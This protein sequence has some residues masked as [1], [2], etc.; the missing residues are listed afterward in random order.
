LGDFKGLLEKS[1]DI[2][3]GEN[4]ASQPTQRTS[5]PRNSSP[6]FSQSQMILNQTQIQ[7]S[8]QFQNQ[9]PMQFQAQPRAMPSLYNPMN[10]QTPIQNVNTQ[11]RSSG[12]FQPLQ[13][14]SSTTS[15]VAQPPAWSQYSGFDNS[16][17]PSNQAINQGRVDTSS[18]NRPG[19]DQVD[20]LGLGNL[21][22]KSEGLNNKSK[23]SK[24][25]EADDKDRDTEKEKETDDSP[26][27]KKTEAAPGFI[28]RI[29]GSFFKKPAQVHLPDES[30][31]P[32]KW[33]PQNKRWF[34]PNAKPEE[35]AKVLP[36]PPTAPKVSSFAQQTNVPT[37]ASFN[38]TPNNA[39]QNQPSAAAAPNFGYNSSTP[40]FPTPTS[41]SSSATTQTTFASAMPTENPGVNIYSAKK[42][43]KTRSPV[44]IR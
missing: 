41:S 35:A 2:I 5:S 4:N 12:F 32:L 1:L 26:K 10:P 28:G 43:Q 8:T 27:G 20:D 11:N 30:S 21:K 23:D 25:T 40:S 34:D 36:P 13:I 24:G 29:V 14:P 38:F 18:T 9:P 31:S 42:H 7:T 16:A 17:T 6:Q 19:D 15:Q 44:K 3:V 22:R 33:D 39:N 37:A